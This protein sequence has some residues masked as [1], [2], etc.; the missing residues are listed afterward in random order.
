MSP[1]N[2]HWL[3]DNR[4]TYPA[5]SHDIEVDIVVVGAALWCLNVVASI[6]TDESHS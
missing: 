2:V 6:A 5:L 1:S 3:I 4:F